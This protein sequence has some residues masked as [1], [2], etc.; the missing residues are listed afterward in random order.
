MPR[1][2]IF[3]ASNGS[4]EGAAG[5]AMRTIEVNE[6]STTPSRAAA[7]LPEDGQRRRR[8]G[9]L[10]DP[11]SRPISSE[12]SESDT[13]PSDSERTY[14]QAIARAPLLSADEEVA[15]ALRIRRGDLDARRRFIEA[16]LR[17]VVFVA[18]RYSGLGVSLPDL[19]QEGNIGLIT[20]VERFDPDRGVRFSTHAY[21]WIR[22]SITRALQRN[23]RLTCA[24]ADACSSDVS[25][26]GVSTA[27]HLILSLDAPV[28]D[29][30]DTSLGDAVLA[31]HDEEPQARAMASMCRDAL[32]EVLENLPPRQRVILS[33][34]HGL[35]DGVEH[36]N[37][38]IARFVGL[39]RESIR[40]IADRSMA[41]IQ[42]RKDIG[43]L[44]YS[45]DDA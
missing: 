5:A 23:K 37:A 8:L 40:Q 19:I 29:E 3:P 35:L 21:W 24:P 34:R 7:P 2:Q 31:S 25:H 1:L 20:A 36:N 43:A 30:E 4:S 26:V 15:L 12:A 10:V 32:D 28:F 45:L 6:L 38:Q 33:L 11:G 18:R 22:Q 41:A 27:I 17:L 42:A 14:M 13:A 39:S 44:R 9:Q 16:N